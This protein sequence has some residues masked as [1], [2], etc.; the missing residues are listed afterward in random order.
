MY[1]IFIFIYRYNIYL[2]HKYLQY[3]RVYTIHKK[4]YNNSD[5]YTIYVKKS[6]RCLQYKILFNYKY[7][8]WT[9]KYN[10]FQFIKIYNH[11]KT[12]CKILKI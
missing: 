3:I 6:T 2:V 4:K 11:T 9:N 5:K 1:I 12:Q 7:T 8:M 10:V